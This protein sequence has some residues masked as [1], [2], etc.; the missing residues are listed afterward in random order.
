MKYE[1]TITSKILLTHLASVVLSCAGQS[2][3]LES[4]SGFS[5]TGTLIF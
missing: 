5:V 1:A 4:K 3:D 2:T